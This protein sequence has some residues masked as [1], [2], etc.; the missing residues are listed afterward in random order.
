MGSHQE[1]LLRTAHQRGLR[2]PRVPAGLP[3]L[4]RRPGTRDQLS[5]V[6]GHIAWRP[7]TDLPATD[8]EGPRHHQHVSGP[9]E[10][11]RVLASDLQQPPNVARHS[12]NTCAAVDVGSEQAESRQQHGG[13]GQDHRRLITGA[14]R[15]SRVRPPAV[16]AFPLRLHT[17][18][19]V[20]APPG[21]G[22]IGRITAMCRLGSSTANAAASCGT[23]STRSRS[24]VSISQLDRLIQAVPATLQRDAIIIIQGDHGS[25]IVRKQPTGQT[26]PSPAD[27]IDGFSTLF[28][29]KSP[30]LRA[31]Y[32]R[33]M[34][35][36]TC[37]LSVLGQTDFHSVDGLEAC[38]GIPSV[39]VYEE[40][41]PHAADGG[42]DVVARLF[43]PFGEAVEESERT[44]GSTAWKQDVR[45]GARR[46][47]T[48]RRNAGLVS[49]SVE[50]KA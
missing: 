45:T 2:D 38:T 43:P 18:T 19:A 6:C 37:I 48:D 42:R 25:R 26:R 10:H 7:G 14:A 12:A 49:S 34:T 31:G 32:D 15:G 36:I 46:P 27:L 33:R 29:V 28:A 13:V 47:P 9:L 35:S 39:F 21:S 23:R 16:T 30:W 20:Y 41:L 44:G 40:T 50:T 1:R 22:S 3:Q 24:S 4:L 17:G 11:L 5:H 8:A